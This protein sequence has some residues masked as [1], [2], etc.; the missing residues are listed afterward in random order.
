[1][2]AKD[3]SNIETSMERIAKNVG[4]GTT[5]LRG[6]MELILSEQKTTWS[7]SGKDE[8]QC[9]LLA[10]RVAGRQI[11]SENDKVKRSGCTNFEGM[12]LTSP[13]Y[14]DWAEMSYK[15][16]ATTLSSGD[17]N[18]RNALVEQGKIVVFEYDP[19]TDGY[20]KHSN[21]SLDRKDDFV[22]GRHET[23]VSVLP[24]E[25][26][27]I[28]SNTHYYLV[29]N[30]TTPLFPSGDKNFKYGAARPQSEKE[31]TCL[32]F[33]RKQGSSD[34]STWTFRFSGE[35]ANNAWPTY[36]PGSIGMRPAR[37]GSTAYGKLKV[38][39]FVADDSL[40]ESFPADPM[41]IVKQEATE[42]LEKGLQDL[43]AY[44]A[45]HNGDKD[46]WDQWVATSTEV[47]HIDPR[48]K[49]G[50]IITVGDSDIESMA[51]TVDIYVDEK[52]G[53]SIN[54]GVGSELLIVGAP[55]QNRDGE[56]Q[57]S[58]TGCGA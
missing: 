47:V 19:E 27:E 45:A 3:M 43:D 37:N 49:G 35:L 17:E 8:E 25:A 57:L 31:R 12:F 30:A 11:K 6:R 41:A 16:M 21:A 26:V 10:L 7:E 56:M 20:T 34:W 51:P 1:M 24:K 58:I 36:T 40:T 52:E 53:D 29:W 18:I 13:R 39:N 50:Y 14:K 44:Y 48:D 28:D 9:T 22:A 4:C 2:E 33:G 42:W 54:F 55:W 38:S 5:A 23:N 46:W 32:F 15:K